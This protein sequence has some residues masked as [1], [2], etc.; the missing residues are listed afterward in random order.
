MR[1]KLVYRAVIARIVIGCVL[2]LFCGMSVYAQG[3]AWEKKRGTSLS[4][5]ERRERL[6]DNEYVALRMTHADLARMPKAQEAHILAMPVVGMGRSQL[7][8]GLM[9]GWMKA[10]GGYLKVKSSFTSAPTDDGFECDE[11][12]VL[13]ASDQHALEGKRPWYSGEKKKSRFAVTA[14]VLR[15]VASPLYLFAGVGYGSRTLAW[16]T[17]DGQWVKNNDFSFAG[18]EAELGALLHWGNLAFSLGVQTNSFKYVEGNLGVGV[19]F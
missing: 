7:S 16:E 14:G 18:V 3:P 4:E 11:E 1:N 13:L 19:M 17:V 10:T 9:L 8:G 12:G 5:K 2:C 6:P 15:K